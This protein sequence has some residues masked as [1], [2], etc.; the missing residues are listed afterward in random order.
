MMTKKEKTDYTIHAVSDALDILEQFH[1]EV[2]EFGVAEL[3]RRL[4]LHKNKVFRLLATLESRD[5]IEQNVITGNYRLGLKN[6]HLGQ[7]FSKQM[8]ILRQA[9][10]VQESLTRKCNETSYVAIMKDFQIICL[11]AVE[12]DL[13][14]RVVP[15]VGEKL[16]IYCTAAGKVIA[17]SLNEETLWEYIRAGELKRYTKNTISDPDELANHLRNIPSRGYAEDNEEL[18]VGVKC[19]G[20]PIRDF[21]RH[22]IGAV[23]ISGPSM[24]LSAE[25]MNRELIPL[26]KN[27]AE[28]ISI[29]LG[30]Y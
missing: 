29:R 13:P 21:T 23:S 20:A 9:R 27:A 7:T 16:P 30:Y 8:G 26:V 25:R 11:N 15:R 14:V 5:Y 12:S 3:S 18:D 19:V 2:D 1:D 6:L 17:A 24:R 28:E 10:P 22:V 4:G